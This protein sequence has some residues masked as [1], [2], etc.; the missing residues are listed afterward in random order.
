MLKRGHEWSMHA[1]TQVCKADLCRVHSRLVSLH[2]CGF[3]RGWGR[4]G[5]GRE[6]N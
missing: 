6:W 2:L 3:C 5:V 4:G 1:Q